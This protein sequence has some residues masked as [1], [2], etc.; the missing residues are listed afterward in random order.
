MQQ[1]EL[2]IASPVVSPYA[3]PSTPG[4]PSG[5]PPPERRVLHQAILRG[6][7]CGGATMAVLAW[8]P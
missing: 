1:P 7:G 3:V 6:S 2:Y 4:L 8:L 5:L